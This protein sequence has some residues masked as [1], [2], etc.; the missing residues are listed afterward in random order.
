MSEQEEKKPDIVAWDKE[1]GYFS[2]GLTYGT[3][4]GAPAIKVD[5]VVGWRSREAAGVNHQLGAKFD[6]L[7]MEMEKLY[8]EYNWNELIYNHA[9]Y[10]FIPVIGHVYHLYRREDQSIFMSLI[11]PQ[12]WAKEHLGSFRLDSS[13][14]W[15]KQQ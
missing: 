13:N 15:C 9:H 14:K 7:R 11:E 5:D 8:E 1:R 4:L 10:S 2:K 12:F 3:N 6:E